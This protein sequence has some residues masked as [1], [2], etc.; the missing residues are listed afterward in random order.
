MRVF[1]RTDR[2]AAAGIR[3]MGL[4]DATG[5]YMASDEHTG[6]W[7]SDECSIST[8]SVTQIPCSR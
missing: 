4:H 8:K 2:E 7:V 5:Q 3:I 1:H 6:V